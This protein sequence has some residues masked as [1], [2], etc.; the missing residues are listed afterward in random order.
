MSLLE[1]YQT[2]LILLAV[3]LG[4]L[5]GQLPFIGH[6]AE[7]LIIPCLV[8][9]LYG[10]FLNIPLHQFKAAFRNIKFLGLS[11]ILNFLWTPLLAWFLGWIF[12]A[13]HPALW[14]GF[15]MLM[16]TPCTDWYLMF[17][18]IA[19]GN[20]ALSASI[21]PVNLVLQVL[22]LPVY[23]MIFAGTIQTIPLA[24]LTE[25]VLVVLVI[26]FVLAHTTR[27]L[28]RNKESILN[29]KLGPFF[30]SAQI[31]FLCLAILAMFASQGSILVD[32]VGA[33]YVLILP[34]LLYFGINFIVGLLTGK[35][36]RLPSADAISL[37][38]TIVA[39]NSPVAL[40]IAV[41]AFPDQPL[42]S[43][44][45]VVGPLI[46]LPVLAVITQGLLS[47]YHNKK[48]KA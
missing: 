23:L 4:L 42:I 34:V 6:H 5:L 22:L 41:T 47:L 13:D 28:L 18:G 30:S 39:R 46:E 17:T 2:F 10:L 35:L 43:L 15:I 21:L 19:K 44:A 32:N 31:I 11:S 3:G 48:Q 38:L 26:P 14:I 37:N 8:F 29:N 1:K 24:T 45:L 27:F 25:S 20:V 9:M 12:L 36:F 33:I 16:V 7:N 40:A